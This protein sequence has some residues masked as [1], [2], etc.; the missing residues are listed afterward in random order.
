[1]TEADAK[2]KWANWFKRRLEIA[3]WSVDEFARRSGIG[4]NAGYR[5]LKAENVPGP[6]RVRRVAQAFGVDPREAFDAASLP[7]LIEGGEVIVATDPAEVFV[8][9][10]RSRGFPKAVEESLIE[11]VRAEIERRRQTL[12][13]ELDTVAVAIG[14]P[15][16]EP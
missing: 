9:Q 5:W 12:E 1:M 7:Y 10:I 16:N 3:N 6:D 8:Q 13:Q 14:K 15:R 2:R 11:R 4:R